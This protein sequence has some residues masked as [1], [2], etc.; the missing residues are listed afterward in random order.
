[1]FNPFSWVPLRVQAPIPLKSTRG[2][3]IITGT[4]FLVCL[5]LVGQPQ[6]SS[7]GTGRTSPSM[8]N[9]LRLEGFE[10]C[11]RDVCEDEENG[12][13][14]GDGEEGESVWDC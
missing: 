12:S 9:C 2:S 7:R 13:I 11:A 14:S 5:A 3:S 1:M 6:P 10:E 8:D 4:I